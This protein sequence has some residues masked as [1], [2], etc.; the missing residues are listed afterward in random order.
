VIDRREVLFTAGNLGLLPG[1]VEKDYVLGWLLAGIR[2]H[3]T[4]AEKWVFKGGTCLKKCYF[5]T[6]RFSED[7]DFTVIEESQLNVDSLTSVFRDISVWIYEKAG[8]TLP[9]DKIRFEVFRNNRD[10]MAG[11]GRISYRGPIAPAARDL[12]R[13]KLD[14]TTDEALILPP[15]NRLVLHPYSDAPEHGIV[16]RC[17]TYEEVFAEKVRA[18]AERARPRDLYD[19]IN[20]FRQDEFR[21]ASTAIREILAKKCLFKE[22]PFPSMETLSPLKEQLIED[23]ATMLRHQLPTLPPVD[24]FWN[25][26]P[27]VFA[28]IEEGRRPAIPA[29]FPLAPGEILM[30]QPAGTISVPG[31]TTTAPLEIIRFAASNRLCVEL[32]Y[33]DEQGKR[34]VQIIEPYSLRRTRT[35]DIILYAVRADTKAQCNYRIDRIQR[36]QA[37]HQS[38]SPQYAIELTP[39]GSIAIPPKAS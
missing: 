2:N 38:F 10:R 34:D 31:M 12:P 9:L 27:T 25:E 18:L 6:Y 22:I 29:A 7:L 15:I 4:I 11:E 30:R 28:W 39:A 5:E 36:V 3:P 17:Y 1:T 8:I 21:P 23:W 33:M 13:I 35:G 20:L 19:V 26:L 37:S 14:L 24:A 16:A 32:D